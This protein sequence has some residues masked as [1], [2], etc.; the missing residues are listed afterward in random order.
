VQDLQS[1]LGEQFQAAIARAYGAEH[2]KTDPLVRPAQNA[3]FGDYQANVAMSLAKR[4]GAKPRDVAQKIVDVLDHGAWAE[5][6]EIAGPGFVNIHLRADFL[7]ERARNAAKDAQLGVAHAQKPQTV[8]VDYSSP[9]VAKEMHVGH[10]RSTIIGDSIARTLEFLGHRVIRQ[11]HIGDWGTQFGLLIEFML[12]NGWDD[13]AKASIGDLVALYKAAKAKFD[14]DEAF[15]DRSRKRVVMLQGGDEKTL[16]LWRALIDQSAKHFQEVYAK[17]GVQLTLDDVRGES[18]YNPM[19][20]ETVRALD[21]KG[22]TTVSDGALCV[23]PPGYK[24]KE[25]EP[26]PVI[27]RKSDGGYGYAATDLTAIRYRLGHL[28]AQRVV[29]VTDARQ[30]QHFAMVFDVA[31]I[32][33]WVPEGVRLEHVPFGMILGDDNQPFKTRSGDTVRLAELLDEAEE[34]AA[35][36][37]AE[38]K[39]DL[40]AATQ[41]DVARAIGIGAVKYADLSSDRVKNYEFSWPR[42]LS[43]DGN[44]APYLQNAY[45]RTRALFRKINL[46]GPPADATVVLTHPAERAL[47]LTLMQFPNA[48]ESVAESLEPHR[49]CGYLH[50]LAA[51]F[52]Q[53]WEHCPVKDAE[54]ALRDSRLV[55]ADFTGRTLA[56]GLELLGIGVVERM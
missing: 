8:V 55:L 21:E 34:R 23:F 5:K 13:P 56:R 30:A 12:D 6:L 53:F 36:I 28:G 17:L 27:V 46:A 35:A 22:I 37:L 32:A 45:V 1:F 54:P 47:A 33:G 15:A 51:A 3:R 42:M 18:F 24:T 25:G 26:L 39:T 7:G 11:N 52:H 20:G 40:D 10:L 31:R 43:F 44:T 49:L 16:G 41:K 38:K 29:Y 48:V 4:V 9:N 19:L 2:S 50:G 14:R